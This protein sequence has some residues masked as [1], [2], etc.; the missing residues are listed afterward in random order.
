MEKMFN[1][2]TVKLLKVCV[3]HAKSKEQLEEVEEVRLLL[4]AW[5]LG[6]SIF[7]LTF[8]QKNFRNKVQK[9]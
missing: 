7:K 5:S 6:I 8:L 2:V 3:L 4:G 1:S 9:G